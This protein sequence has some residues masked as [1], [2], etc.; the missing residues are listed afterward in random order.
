MNVKRFVIGC[1][2]VYIVYQILGFLIHQVLLGDI[3]K[4]LE[5]VWRPE[6]QM[7]SKMW[8]MWLTSAVWT[9]LFCYIFTRGYEVANA[10]VVALM[11][12][13]GVILALTAI[14]YQLLGLAR[15]SG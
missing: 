7:M 13:Y 10:D 3:Y 6:A 5:S 4:V 15:R 11:S 9:V 1:A 8:I 2:A 14:V 12:E